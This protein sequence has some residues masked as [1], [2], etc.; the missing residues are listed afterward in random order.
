[1]MMAVSGS[2][3][4][5]GVLG[6]I[7]YRALLACAFMLFSS[8]LL[9]GQLRCDE[10]LSLFNKSDDTTYFSIAVFRSNVMPTIRVAESE[11]KLMLEYFNKELRLQTEECIYEIASRAGNYRY[12]T[13]T[14]EDMKCIAD[15]VKLDMSGLT[16]Q[17]VSCIWEGFGA[18]YEILV[19][20]YTIAGL[21]S[22]KIYFKVFNKNDGSMKAIKST[23]LLL[24]DL[25]QEFIGKYLQEEVLATN[26][27][28]DK[29]NRRKSNNSIDSEGAIAKKP[30][31]LP[32]VSQAGGNKPGSVERPIKIRSFKAPDDLYC[33]G[34][35]HLSSGFFLRVTEEGQSLDQATA[36]KKAMANARAN[37]LNEMT[38]VCHYVATSYFWNETEGDSDLVFE[39]MSQAI[40]RV[41]YY[42]T[43]CEK[44]IRTDGSVYK[45]F[46]CVEL[47][48]SIVLDDIV[49]ALEM[50]ENLS[51]DMHRLRGI[52]TRYF[53]RK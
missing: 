19:G 7:F 34:E 52:Y 36:K 23:W 39:I 3:N 50:N 12:I 29:S 13:R 35:E 5:K 10:L 11:K 6:S 31:G 17:D 1:M 41:A 14:D 27:T 4:C 26:V 44:S 38:E 42:R 25:D 46:V 32:D 24:N 20:D 43:I 33:K 49:R 22:M 45:T 18:V 15:E 8:V 40:E 30:R 48:M 28:L 2:R 16:D 51:L 47:D 53:D 9:F 21:D 37:M